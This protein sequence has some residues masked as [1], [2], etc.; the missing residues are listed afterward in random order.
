MAASQRRSTSGSSHAWHDMPGIGM[1]VLAT[2][3][4]GRRADAEMMIVLDAVA[5]TCQ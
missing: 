5:T 2:E 1:R 3:D 4:R